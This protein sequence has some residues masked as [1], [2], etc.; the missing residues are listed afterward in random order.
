MTIKPADATSAPWIRIRRHIMDK[1]ERLRGYLEN[2]LDAIQTARIRGEI[3]ALRQ[4]VA[5]VDG[6][7]VS[8][9]EP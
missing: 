8:A 6:P 9:E 2:D 4:L 5:D 3:N 7:I 1:I